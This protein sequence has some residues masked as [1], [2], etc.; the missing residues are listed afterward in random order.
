MTLEVDSCVVGT[1]LI[2]R[3][4]VLLT[5]GNATRALAV[6]QQNSVWVERKEYVSDVL[7]FNIIIIS[8]YSNI[9]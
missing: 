1:S 3:A 9:F 4:L 2:D 6:Y 7:I 8:N 5:G